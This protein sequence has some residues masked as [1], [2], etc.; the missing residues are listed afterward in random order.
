[1]GCNEVK[2][3]H[4]KVEGRVQ[5]VWYRVWAQKKAV[6]HEIRGWIR[7]RS[8]GTVEAVVCG[9]ELAINKLLEAMKTGPTMA[10]VISIRAEPCDP[11]I[12][13]SFDV[14]K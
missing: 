4:V 10:N 13:Y 1:M 9:R 14:L 11:P 8:D 12:N 5:G 2:S 7:N 6:N 3:Y